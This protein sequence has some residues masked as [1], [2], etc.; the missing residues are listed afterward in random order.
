[1]GAGIA[2]D[3]VL[4]LKDTTA[5]DLVFIGS[6][7][8]LNGVGIGDIVAVGKACNAESFSTYYDSAKSFTRLVR[9]AHRVESSRSLTGKTVEKL[10]EH[11]RGGEI[12]KRGDVFTTGSLFCETETNIR[13]LERAG[14]SAIE[15]ELSAVMTAAR[16]IRIKSAAALFISDEPLLKPLWREMEKE[17]KNKYDHSIDVIIKSVIDLFSRK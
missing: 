3:C 4:A 2:G 15:M 14:F 8:G 7:G 1:M 11:A 6:A 5:S 13:E 16:V 10:T 17:E 9:D 12:V